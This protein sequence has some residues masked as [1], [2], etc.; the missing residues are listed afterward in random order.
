M[1]SRNYLI[2]NI[3]RLKKMEST[4]SDPA[5]IEGEEEEEEEVEEEGEEEQEDI[6]P[7]EFCDAN[8]T[9]DNLRSRTGE[10]GERGDDEDGYSDIDCD[11]N[12]F[13]EMSMAESNEE[14]RS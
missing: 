8:L 12:M 7:I 5:S 11:P 10:G 6:S 2:G 14:V 3:C 1:F 9:D 13:C 4:A